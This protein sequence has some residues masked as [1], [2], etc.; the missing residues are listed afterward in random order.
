M[1]ADISI[2][3]IL[4]TDSASDELVK[5]DLARTGNLLLA[6]A[7]KQGKSHC[8]HNLIRQR[9]DQ[10]AYLHRWDRGIQQGHRTFSC[11]NDPEH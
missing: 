10:R 11:Q 6:G 9:C 7:T 3:L 2:P 4:G 5:I 1:A 8:I